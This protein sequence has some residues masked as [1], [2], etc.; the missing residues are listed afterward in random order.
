MIKQTVYS[1]HDDPQIIYFHVIILSDSGKII[2][3]GSE[4]IKSKE[5]QDSN[6]FTTLK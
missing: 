2:L 3:S 1:P 5:N 4:K 6:S